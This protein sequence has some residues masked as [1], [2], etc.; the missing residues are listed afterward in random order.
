M[1]LFWRLRGAWK[2]VRCVCARSPYHP[3]SVVQ[4]RSFSSG[5]S[6]GIYLNS[7]SI[8]PCILGKEARRKKKNT[9]CGGPRKKKKKGKKIGPKSI[10][11]KVLLP[12]WES[13]PLTLR[14]K[15]IAGLVMTMKDDERCLSR[16]R[17]E[18]EKDKGK[19]K[20]KEKESE[21][22]NSWLF[23]FYV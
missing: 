11:N 12:F 21:T 16:K 2:G 17:K 7:I 10:L 6:C 13:L 15:L 3:T 5:G 4:S 19:E 20:E 22:R 14:A 23:G 9:P 8:F 18:K 1:E